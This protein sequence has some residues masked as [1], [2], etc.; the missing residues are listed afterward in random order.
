MLNQQALRSNFT[1]LAGHI[2]AWFRANRNA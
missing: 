1:F 2:Y